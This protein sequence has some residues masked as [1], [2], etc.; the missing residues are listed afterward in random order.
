MSC[1]SH[2]AQT[3]FLQDLSLTFLSL[4]CWLKGSVQP[5]AHE[6][7]TEIQKSLPDLSGFPSHTLW[8]GPQTAPCR[9]FSSQVDCEE[10]RRWTN[11]L[12]QPEQLSLWGF[13]YCWCGW[14]FGHSAALNCSLVLWLMNVNPFN[15]TL[16]S[17]SQH[18]LPLL[19]LSQSFSNGAACKMVSKNHFFTSVA[20]S[21]VLFY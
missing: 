4:P 14:K 9:L 18:Y 7:M 11:L 5:S 10:E 6:A 21:G 16:S 2:T 19:G 15:V 13:M 8:Q 3:S 1:M 12:F 20:C 17:P